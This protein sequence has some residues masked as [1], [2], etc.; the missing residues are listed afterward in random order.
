[1]FNG[2]GRKETSVKDFYT[3]I[4]HTSTELAKLGRKDIALQAIV[5]SVGRAAELDSQFCSKGRGWSDRH[6][7]IQKIMRAGQPLPPIQVFMVQRGAQPEYYVV[8]GHHR[9]AVALRLGFD[10]LN[11][12]IT[13]VTLSA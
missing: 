5:G 9:V 6:Q 11:A 3:E 12:D 2:F 10:T 8:D 7:T 13:E 1:M 4:G